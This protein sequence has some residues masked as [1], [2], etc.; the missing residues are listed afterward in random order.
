MKMSD[1]TQKDVIPQNLNFESLIVNL[2][3]VK[4]DFEAI[5]QLE[6]TTKAEEIALISRIFE[7]L[8][9]ILPFVHIRVLLHNSEFYNGNNWQGF[10]IASKERYIIL[11]EDEDE[12]LESQF[13]HNT[14]TVL[15]VLMDTLEIRKIIRNGF[16]S[17]WENSQYYDS[18]MNYE[19]YDSEEQLKGA[20]TKIVN[21]EFEQVTI[22]QLLT[23]T[24]LSVIIKNIIK[25]FDSAISKIP[26]KKQ[27]LESRLEQLQTI[28][29]LLV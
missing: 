7:R 12:Y 3:N 8:Y 25:A 2:E 16:W 24:D 11:S 20:I 9:P 6:S 18:V 27:Q 29:S 28:Q 21:Q 10:R 14:Q 26:A 19:Q 23:A 17:N 1:P 22:E 15:Y 13:V 4:A 5:A